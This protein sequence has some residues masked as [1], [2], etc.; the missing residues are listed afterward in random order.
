MHDLS[1]TRELACQLST[2][3]L[4]PYHLYLEGWIRLMLS[5]PCLSYLSVVS[6][7]LEVLL[8]KSLSSGTPSCYRGEEE[9]KTCEGGLNQDLFHNTPPKGS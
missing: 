5:W 4:Q 1:P 9:A 7:I 2:W 8:E 3:C 6:R